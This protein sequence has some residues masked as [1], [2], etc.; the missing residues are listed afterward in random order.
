MAGY[1]RCQTMFL[2]V[3]GGDVKAKSGVTLG[4]AAIH[5]DGTWAGAWTTVVAPSAGAG[6]TF[7]LPA[8]T[9]VLLRWT[10]N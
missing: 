3:P 1:A 8:A 7:N 4:G 5:N 10:R 2:S 6:F 9:A